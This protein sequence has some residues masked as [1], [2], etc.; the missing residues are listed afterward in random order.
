MMVSKNPRSKLILVRPEEM[1]VAV[2]DAGE[3]A[4]EL[5][6]FFSRTSLRSVLSPVSR[7]QKLFL[8][9]VVGWISTRKPL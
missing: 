1:I 3:H 4:K 6:G 7:K 2:C 5:V 9:A 8:K